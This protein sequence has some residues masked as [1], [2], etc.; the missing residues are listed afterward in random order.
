MLNIR[1]KRILLV[2]GIIVVTILSAVFLWYFTHMAI[3]DQV[4]MIYETKETSEYTFYY[5]QGYKESTYKSSEST[6]E[7]SHYIVHYVSPDPAGFNIKTIDLE[8][9]SQ[10]VDISSMDKCKS[11]ISESGVVGSKFNSTD[12]MTT[13]TL[14]Y[15]KEISSEHKEFIRKY[16]SKNNKTG[17]MFIITARDTGGDHI[18]ELETAA[19]HF[20]LKY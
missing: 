10:P 19:E 20:T 9:V 8:E 6:I 12:A 17:K 4:P 3:I 1:K 5:P 15:S 14:F 11:L 2:I 13:C 16:F 18:E 7:G